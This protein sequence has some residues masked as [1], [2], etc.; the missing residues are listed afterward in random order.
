MLRACRASNAKATTPGLS[1]LALI[2]SFVMQVVSQRRRPSPQLS[3]ATG[4]A[5]LAA[6]LMLLVLSG[7][8]HSLPLIVAGSIAAGAG[9]GLAFLNAQEE[10]NEIAP[11][12]R[13]G[14]V[15]AAFIACIYAL[16]AS[17]VIATGLLDER[18]SLSVSVDAVVIVLAAC[19][20][21]T[22]GWQARDREG[23]ETRRRRAEAAARAANLSR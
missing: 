1:A 9:H 13:R 6:G 20:L 14:E 16:V 4:L 21:A 15:T 10:L 22:T 18:F 11:E 3:Q 17:S 23:R 12:D 19:S 8:A 7:P 2:A 5:V